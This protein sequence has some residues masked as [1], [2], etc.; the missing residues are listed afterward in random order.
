M[1]S[2]SAAVSELYAMDT[3]DIFV[4]VPK[5]KV[6]RERAEQTW[7]PTWQKI[8]L[9]LAAIGLILWI[10]GSVVRQAI[11]YDLFVQGTL[12]FKPELPPDA[13]AQT[14]RLYSNTA[15][16]IW[17]GYALALLGFVPVFISMFRRWRFYGW[18]FMAGVL[19]L[20]FVPL[21]AIFIYFD[22][23]LT[24]AVGLG[25]GFN[26]GDAKEL[27]L[28][29]FT[30]RFLGDFGSGARWL[31][32]FGYLAAV[33]VLVWRPLHKEIPKSPEQ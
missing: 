28:Q 33:G 17:V 8:L 7:L 4:T 5:S 6:L 1:T 2:S 16:Y 22:W 13:V 29:S 20:M 12:V 31:T 19:L 26:I 3:P 9:T 18:L 32:L 27:L 24:R 14:L 30:L 11:A 21:E 23:R 15:I 10:G 25:L